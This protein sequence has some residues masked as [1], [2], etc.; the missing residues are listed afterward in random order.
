MIKTKALTYHYSE[1]R[2]FTYKDIQSSSD[3]LLII[4]PSGSGKTTF[5]HLLAGLLRP[6]DGSIYWSDHNINNLSES[7]LDKLRGQKLGLSLIHI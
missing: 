5:L 2:T 1:D 4:G 7:E 6:K 3:P